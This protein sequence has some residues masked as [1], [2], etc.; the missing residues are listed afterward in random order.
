L[1]FDGSAEVSDPGGVAG[2]GDLKGD[3]VFDPI[4]PDAIGVVRGGG[5]RVLLRT[6]IAVES[7]GDRHGFAG[8]D[9]SELVALEFG[10]GAVDLRADAGADHDADDGIVYRRVEFD[11]HSDGHR[12]TA[13]EDHGGLALRVAGLKSRY[14]GAAIAT[15]ERRRERLIYWLRAQRS[16]DVLAV[17][18]GDFARVAFGLER[19]AIEPPDFVGDGLDERE[20]VRGDEDG[21]VG[22]ALFFDVG[23]GAGFA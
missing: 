5:N 15:A 4:V 7:I 20:I 23:E 22:A 14:F 11:G 17:L 6:E 19:A 1:A 18:L 10:V 13:G 12:L 16:G 21:C 9:G 8:S 3:G 2:V